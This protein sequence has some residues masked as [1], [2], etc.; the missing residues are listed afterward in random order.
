MG[1]YENYKVQEN[2]SD[3]GLPDLVLR[4]TTIEKTDLIRQKWLDNYFYGQV[5]SVQYKND[6][7]ALTIGGG[8]TVY[9]GVHHGDVIWAQFGID[10]GYRYYDLDALKSDINV[11][12]KWQYQFS[13]YWNLFTDMQY[14]HVQHKMNGFSNNP[15]LFI[16]RKFDFFNPKAGIMYN[17]NGWQSY[18]SYA[19]ANKEPNRDDFE[20]GITHQPK[21]ETLHDFEAGIE[22]RTAKFHAGATL[23]YMQYKDQLVLTGKINDVGAYTRTNVPDSYRAGVEL[24]GGYIFSKWINAVANISFS[25]NKIKA[26]TEYLDDYDVDFNSLDQKA[27]LHEKTDIAFSPSVVGRSYTEYITCKKY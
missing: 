1:Y 15:S 16:N 10:N 4:D 20:A 25:R 9:D 18:F 2:F 8:W 14:R 24:Q 27:I 19:L 5:L 6:K 11:Y 26:F 13:A 12:A 3:Y 22:K 23:Y 7:H 17:K 21:K